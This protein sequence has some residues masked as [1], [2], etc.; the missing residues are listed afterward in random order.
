M[1]GETS[2]FAELSQNGCRNFRHVFISRQPVFKH[3]SPFTSAY[4]VGRGGTSLFPV[5]LH[6][7]RRF[8]TFECLSSYVDYSSHS[9]VTGWPTT[10]AF[11]WLIAQWLLTDCPPQMF[12]SFSFFFFSSFFFTR[13]LLPVLFWGFFNFF[14][15]VHYVTIWYQVFCTQLYDITREGVAPSSTLSCSSYRK[16]SVRVTLA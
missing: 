6:L 2:F 9:S 10:R 13:N 11:T 16:G 8:G 3:K 14:Y 5:F 15:A 7:R 4:G 12:F 1:R